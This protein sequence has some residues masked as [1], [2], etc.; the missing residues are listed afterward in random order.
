MKKVAS[1][2]LVVLVVGLILTGC[3]PTPAPTPTPEPTPAPTPAPEPTP[4]NPVTVTVAVPVM[5]LDKKA[6][7]VIMGSGFEPGQE[8]RVLFITMD[9]GRSDIGYSL[10]PEP[11]AN[12]A[13]A[14]ATAWTECGSRYIKK[15]LI[16]EGIYTII[17]TDS[18]YNTLASAPIAF[19]DAGQEEL[20][21]WASAFAK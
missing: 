19:Y 18:E 14:W 8:V 10:D 21:S 4:A 17:V 11:V 6:Q 1:V 7:A 16:G 9:G 5:E 15:G 20:P 13:G 12:E 3:A 2:L